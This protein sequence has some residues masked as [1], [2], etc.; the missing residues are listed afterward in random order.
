MDSG[1]AEM[2]HEVDVIEYRINKHYRQAE[3]ELQEKI[4]KF[5]KDFDRLD[6][7]KRELVESGKMTEAEYKTWRQNKIMAGKVWEQR[8]DV[9]SRDLYNAN[10]KA[11]N[12]V[13]DELPDV[14]A[15]A[16]NFATYQIENGAHIDTSYT[17]YNREAVERLIAD[18]P[19]MIPYQEIN[20]AK[21]ISWNKKNLQAVMIQGVLQGE[22]IPHL[23]KRL[24]KTVVQ[25]NR[26]CAIRNARTMA[27]SV[28][29]SG[30][31]DAFKRAEALGVDMKVRWRA[32]F[33]DRTRDSHRRLDGEEV[34]V[35]Q[36][37][38]NG[39]TFPC[40]M[41]WLRAA[42]YGISKSEKVINIFK[43]KCAETYNCRCTIQGVVKGL[44][45]RAEKYRVGKI[46]GLTYEDW[47]K[48]KNVPQMRPKDLPK[49]KPEKKAPEPPKRDLKNRKRRAQKSHE[50]IARVTA[51]LNAFKAT[52]KKEAIES[53]KAV[54]YEVKGGINRLDEK[55]LV[56]NVNRFHELNERFKGIQF[57]DGGSF[58]TDTKKGL[59]VAYV[60]SYGEL[61]QQDLALN[62]R[63]FKSVQILH[64]EAESAVKSFW[65][66]P[67]TEENYNVY[68]ITHEYGHIIE[69]NTMRSRMNFD[70][71]KKRAT[72][73]V[74][75]KVRKRYKREPY[76]Y[77]I[78]EKARKI[79]QTEREKTAADIRD[80]ILQIA[81]DNNKGF[82]LADN[83][84]RYGHKNDFEFFAEVF[85]NSQCG[86]PNEL[87]KA[88]FKW[89]EKEGY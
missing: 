83:L 57:K 27:T 6:Q 21:D 78:S 81:K 76:E 24:S 7:K 53:M 61:A 9:I 37:F 64:D 19:D 62:P 74:T 42:R 59:T 52:N 75:E 50:E 10:Y 60:Q 80:E 15:S 67:C 47:K 79:R 30:K 45:P 38:S 77:E 51:K 8:K 17:L 1:Y 89:L 31:M 49:H 23:A 18:N 70:D 55:L 39:L 73:E 13:Y 71:I 44:E 20:K 4:N 68:T 12:M 32:T 29:N 48:G 5:Y 43:E 65:H 84:S 86:A 28:Y 26:A 85:A 41:E 82:N 2:M 87:G 54:F 11:R 58:Y 56:E 46:H 14:Y 25:K 35:G 33:D 63:Y 88:M 72:E 40:D 66:M 3:K 36:P 22:S 34:Q 16:H 69:N